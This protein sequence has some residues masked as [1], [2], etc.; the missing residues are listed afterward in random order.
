[1]S[2]GNEVELFGVVM[3]EIGLAQMVIEAIHITLT[4]VGDGFELVRYA[5]EDLRPRNSH[6]VPF[7]SYERIRAI[8]NPTLT[9]ARYS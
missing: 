2:L 7:E 8:V 3:D 4:V 5:S 9:S 6:A 1:M